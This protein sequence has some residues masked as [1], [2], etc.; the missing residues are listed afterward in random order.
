MSN[1]PDERSMHILAAYVHGALSALHTLGI[2]YNY[3]KGNKTDVLIH[4]LA[5]AYDAKSTYHHYT[6]AKDSL[7]NKLEQPEWDG[8]MRGYGTR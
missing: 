2:V 6:E 5:L 8:I 3:R 1:K 4:A 7:E